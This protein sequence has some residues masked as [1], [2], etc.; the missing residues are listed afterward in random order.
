[1]KMDRFFF[2]FILILIC[3]PPWR[4]QASEFPKDLR[5]A[6]EMIRDGL[7]HDAV[8]RIRGWLQKNSSSPQ[9]E[10]QVLL[11]EALLVD[12]RSSEA[13]AALPKTP[14]ADMV[15]RVLLVRA[16]ALNE[17]G[18]WKEALADW[19]RLDFNSFPEGQANQARLG[20]ASALLNENQREEGLKQLRQLMEKEKADPA[21]AGAAR[22]LTVKTLLADGKQDEAEKEL[23]AIKDNAPASARVEA[24]YWKAEITAA[25]GKSEEARQLFQKL[26]EEADGAGRD[27]LARAW[28]A[29]GRID[30]T[31]G[32]P[33]DAATALEKALDRGGDPETYLAA[34][35]EYLTAAQASQSLPTA[36]LRLRD[37]V[38]ER[39]NDDEKK[40]R[41]A[42]A[43]LLLGSATLEAGNA[44]AA[45]ADLDNLIKNYPSS[46]AVAGAQVILAEALA[47]QGQESAARDQLRN[48]LKKSDLSGEISF[49]AN[50]ALGD[51][52]LKDG[53][54]FE[55]ATCY[56]TALKAAST[57]KDSENALYNAALATARIPDPVGFA[58]LEKTFSEKFPES[59]RRAAL[60]LE[61][62]RMLESK[63]DS[64]ASRNALEEVAQLPGSGSFQAEAV[65]RRANSLLRA[66]N[67]PEAAAAFAEFEKSFPDSPLLPQ[68][69]ASGIEARLRAKEL[70]G[71]QARA[72]FAKILS[73]FP[74]SALAP[75]LSF[76]I[77]QTHYEE[78]NHGEALTAFREMAKKFPKDPLADNALYYA[79]LSALALGN[80]EEAIK[81]LR[82]LP[83]NSPL[84]P[85]A[86][87]AEIDACRASGDYPGGLLIANSLLANRTPD[88]RPWVEVS[89]RRLACEFALGATDKASLDRAVTTA[90]G[91]LKSPAADAS[92]KN[93]AGFIRGRSLEQLGKEDDALQAYLDV[94]YGRL[95]A[96]TSAPSQ[97]EYL[98]F[99]RSGAEAARIQE[100]RGDFKGA[101]AIYRILEN[102]GGPNQASF[103]RKID[104]LRN[105]HFLWSEQ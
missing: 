48:L 13:L 98:W 38:R 104:D 96:S 45:A 95:G 79:G 51:L 17:A 89:K 80:P 71:T 56:E 93:E 5:V 14:P 22:I 50:F 6:E 77:A 15:N 3:D 62:G 44:E 33:G 100:K 60:A 88:Q 19:K 41:F 67:Y 21:S 86:R 99:A 28:I 75:A 12:G 32:K 18:R 78:K 39:E 59:D 27:L 4:I 73:R 66:G 31:R 83:E 102:A 61:R 43:L 10:A 55:S 30:R 103:A 2:L 87:L 20:L 36:A 76:Q 58:R 24:R 11:A 92:D 1:M 8:A 9:P 81:L 53:K 64:A 85:D 49:Q 94:L 97:P 69:L 82:S 105:R 23:A 25:R 7:A 47:K 26:V 34:A 90:E 68:A 65:L 52:L 40:G 101:L 29:I 70:T 63:G 72:E 42:P 91:I 35:R 74:E 84:R 57:P 46:P 37:S 16:S 54:A